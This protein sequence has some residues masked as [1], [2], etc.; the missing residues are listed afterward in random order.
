M[1]MGSANEKWAA[2]GKAGREGD[3]MHYDCR[4]EAN[5]VL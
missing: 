3:R 2:N 4:A 5:G 1:M